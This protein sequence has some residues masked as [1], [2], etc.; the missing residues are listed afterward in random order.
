MSI[1]KGS[2]VGLQ[3]SPE[4]PSI[5]AMHPSYISNVV[6]NVYTVTVIFVTIVSE[7]M[8]TSHDEGKEEEEDSES[9]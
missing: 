2:L 5:Q 1:L 9:I 8:G 3:F 6:G 7:R 4:L